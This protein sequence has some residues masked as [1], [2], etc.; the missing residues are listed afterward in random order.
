MVRG[1]PRA[2]D[3]SSRRRHCRLCYLRSHHGSFGARDL[4]LQTQRGQSSA[5]WPSV[6]RAQRLPWGGGAPAGPPLGA[7]RR[8]AGVTSPLAVA[9]A[10]SAASSIMPRSVTSASCSFCFPAPEHGGGGRADERAAR[11]AAPANLFICLTI[12]HLEITVSCCR[13]KLP[14]CA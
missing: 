9:R 10:A 6:G 12:M 2:A 11:C 3:A 4:M 7:A 5:G 1:L 14:R 8:V 13:C